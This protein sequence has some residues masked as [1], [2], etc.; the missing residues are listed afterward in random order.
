LPTLLSR[1]TSRFQISVTKAIKYFKRER[2]TF[3]SFKNIRI[4]IR[5]VPIGEIFCDAKSAGSNFDFHM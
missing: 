5:N 3:E 1:E 2:N 4:L